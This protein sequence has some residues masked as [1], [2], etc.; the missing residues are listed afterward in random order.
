MAAAKRFTLY[1]DF[2]QIHLCDPAG[3]GSL[4][5][6]WTAQ[7][8]EDRIADGGDI[9]GI[10]A[11]DTDDVK[12]SVEILAAAPE[13]DAAAWDHVTES[14]V[15]VESGSVAVLGCSDE[16][17]KAKRFPVKP[18]AWRVRASH[19]N[20]AKG[21]EEI[22]LQMWPARRKAP[23]VV[24]RWAPP[25]KMKKV[26]K[27]IA[28]TKQAIQAAL[29]GETDAA[30][31]F[32]L[33]RAEKGDFAA[34]AAAVQ[35][36]A[37][38]GQWREL[39]P[40]AMTVIAEEPEAHAWHETIGGAC[41][42]LRRA[43]GELGDRS[44][45]EAATKK[46]HRKAKAEAL[47]RLRGERKARR[48][49]TAADRAR[50]AEHASSPETEKRF[51]GKPGA[52]A[53]SLMAYGYL[54]LGLEDELLELWDPRH[55]DLGFDKAMWVAEIFARRGDAKRAWEVIESRLSKWWPTTIW[56]VAPVELLVD[57][58]LAPLLTKER[59]ARVLGTA[60]GEEGE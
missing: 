20:L 24:K 55:E 47:P 15:D 45:V 37:F 5:E 6:A 22:R 46:L 8:T 38:R 12:V 57:P 21:R 7:A 43:A 29:R 9:V 48:K 39:V 32:L 35:L 11:K 30:L 41:A 36:L 42:L 54:H 49:A 16:L 50:F 27:K 4:E 19:A 13:D 17:K 25:P 2:G 51:R 58:A 1:A 28:S 18:G 31:A 52:R 26:A 34:S 44:I 33:P 53:D 10:G 3:P 56:D 59:R 14:S 40:L 23:R 60:R